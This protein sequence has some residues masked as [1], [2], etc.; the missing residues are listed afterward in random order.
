MR[1]VDAQGMA[2]R[3]AMSLQILAN[4]LVSGLAIALLALSFQLVYLASRVFFFG[5][6]GTY[7]VVPFIAFAVRASGGGWAVA[8]AAAAGA[9]VAINVLCE[10]A[11]H[12]PLSRRGASGGA[13][14]LSSLGVYL[15]L[16]QAVAMVWGN[17]TKTLRQGVESVVRPGGVVVTGAQLWTAGVSVAL[18]SGFALLLMR[19]N[20]GLRLRALSDNPTQFALLGYNV[21]HHRLLAFALSGLLAAASS[22]LTAYDVGFDPHSGLQAVLLAVVAVIV[23]GQGSFVG[24]VVGALLLGV[25]RTQVIWFWSARWQ[26]A[27]TFALLALVLLLRPRGLMG[28]ATRLEATP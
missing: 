27:V 8:V 19:S 24:P 12:A 15:M 20:L 16:V 14:L 4:G 1:R 7:A 18:L 6:A 10:W 9:G 28:R 23:G 26:E 3:A 22:L 13:Q 11:N 25:A 17:E 5:L 2:W 21:D